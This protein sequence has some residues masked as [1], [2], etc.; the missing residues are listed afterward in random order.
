MHCFSSTAV[1]DDSPSTSG[2]SLTANQTVPEAQHPQRWDVLTG[3]DTMRDPA[4]NPRN[5]EGSSSSSLVL[6][7]DQRCWIVRE[8]RPFCSSIKAAIDGTRRRVK[9]WMIR[10]CTGTAS[11]VRSIGQRFHVSFL[12]FRES[13]EGLVF[14]INHLDPDVSLGLVLG[15]LMI[16]CFL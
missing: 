7:E 1:D 14:R 5:E 12:S 4:A 6:H 10:A 2:H 15:W 9:L 13:L 8:S 16:H 11:G 3:V